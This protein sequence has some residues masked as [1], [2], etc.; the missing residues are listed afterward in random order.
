MILYL[1]SLR[2]GMGSLKMLLHEASN[3][4]QIFSFES[5]VQSLFQTPKS[6]DLS[7]QAFATLSIS[8]FSF[9]AFQNSDSLPLDTVDLVNSWINV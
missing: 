9:K 6:C 8:N 5:V 4:L 1:I 2:E 7:K 3:H